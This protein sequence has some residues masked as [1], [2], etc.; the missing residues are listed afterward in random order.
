PDG[1]TRYAGAPLAYTFG[2]IDGVKSFTVV[3]LDGEGEARIS[4]CEIAPLRPLREL[5][6]TFADLIAKEA[7]ATAYYRVVLT[8]EE[9]VPD[10]LAELRLRFPYIMQLIYDNT[11]TRAAAALSFDED[12]P[13]RDPFTLFSE[14]YELQ[15]GKPLS[16][17]A[18]EVL[19]ETI[20]EVFGHENS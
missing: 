17:E 1:H 20:G 7:D 11:R 18:K 5:R 19:T 2:E 6:G 16:D 13:L 14:F 8:D 4:E 15:N 10:A 9:D 12:L 3:D